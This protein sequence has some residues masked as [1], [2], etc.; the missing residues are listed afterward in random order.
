MPGALLRLVS[1]GLLAAVTGCADGPRPPNLLLV[2]LDT[3]R[4]DALSTYGNPL[5]VTPRIDQLASEGAVFERAFSTDFWT[6]PSHASLF[7]GLYPSDHGATSETNRL[8]EDAVTLA[9]VLADAGYATGGFVSNPWV[10]VERGFSQGFELFSETWRPGR[11]PGASNRLDSGAVREAGDWIAAQ[12][13]AERP[14]FAFLNLNRPHL[15]YD[16]D[17]SLHARLFP[18]PQ[19]LRRV[20]ALKKLAGMWEHL[21]GELI[22]EENDYEILRELYQA[23]VAMTDRLVGE[24]IDRIH[25]LGVL[26]DTVIVV[27]ADHGENIGDHGLIDHTLSMYDST[28]RIPLVVR[29]PA[30]VPA[31]S[32]IRTLASLTDVFPTVLSLL[33]LADDTQAPRSLFD[34]NREAPSHVVAENERP[35]N[36]V[37]LMRRR[38]PDFD[39]RSIDG[40][41]RM[42]RTDRFKLI[43]RERDGET[44]STELY[45]L[46]EDPG[47][48]RNV[49]SH[50]IATRDRLLGL[51]EEWEANRTPAEKLPPLDSNDREAILQLRALGYA[52]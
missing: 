45:D 35:T 13:R 23:E 29:Y 8:G 37:E 36:G 27:T 48:E 3:T 7:T 22:L 21:A 50:E 33:G 44:K 24:L 49:A 40:R 14:F 4:A 15:P 31:G 12:V 6:L 38:F 2:V 18:Q 10:G 43:R 25:A 32:R 17:P 46:E 9:E 1:I 16:P 11:E 19:P 34:P 51:L 47:E 41:M 42:V 39:T 20:A 26:D 52:E 5:P 30:R 28:L